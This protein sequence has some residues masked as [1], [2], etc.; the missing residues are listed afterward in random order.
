MIGE[1]IGQYRIEEKLGEGGVGEVFRAVDLALDRDVAIKRLR[2]ELTVR[3]QLVERFRSEARTLA[4]LNHPNIAT[5]YSLV[6]SSHDL[7]MVMEFVEGDTLAKLLR[8]GSGLP[9]ERALRL[10]TQALDG[11]GYAHE[12]GIIHRD[13]KGSNLMV[14]CCGTLK[15]MDFGIARVLGSERVT[16][17]GQLVG[18]PEFMSPEQ[19]RGDDVDA[20]SDIYSL[21]ILLYALLSGRMP[22]AAQSSFDLM[23]AQVESPPPPIAKLAPNLP[24]GFQP[25]LQRA[26]EKDPAL[27]YQSTAL[28]R[29]ALEPFL[30]PAEAAEAT[31][32]KTP[33]PAVPAPAEPMAV[34]APMVQATSVMVGELTASQDDRPT[35]ERVE[36]V[37]A[38]TRVELEP[39]SG[40]DAATVPDLEL[41]EAADLHPDESN[42]GSDTASHFQSAQTETPTAPET[43]VE[44][45]PTSSRRRHLLAWFLAPSITAIFLMGVNVLWVST[46]RPPEIATPAP[47]QPIDSPADSPQLHFSGTAAEP[48][49]APVVSPAAPAE[50]VAELPP[51]GLVELVPAGPVEPVPAKTSPAARPSDELAA[52]PPPAAKTRVKAKR[53][54][55]PKRA[56]TQPRRKKKTEVRKSS[57]QQPPEK[58]KYKD[59]DEENRGWVVRRR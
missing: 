50:P 35:V 24:A 46:T 13:I 53:S 11:L 37:H 26:L 3:E 22:F 4:Q 8:N 2:P 45:Q 7:L 36:A 5:L 20:R 17:L 44:E 51:A 57:P 43:Q 52:A 14:K 47:P 12:R 15:V 39:E 18:T 32:S 27:R 42:A 31:E 21:G 41:P 48:E 38:T 58:D 59:K 23:K 25:V 16:L 19:I 49:L 33:P 40:V 55:S 29:A 1:T 30:S 34:N 9:L 10:F 28:F 54:R 6:E 56:T